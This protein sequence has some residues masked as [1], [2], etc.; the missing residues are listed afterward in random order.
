MRKY[1]I[2]AAL[3]AAFALPASAAT[4]YYVGLVAKSNKCEVTSTKPDGVKVKM[5][6]TA[7]YS[8][9][10]KASAA[11]KAAADCK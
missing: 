11:M 10:A 7:T 3:V 5:I 1:L 8:T 9:K 4:T 2:A 6:G